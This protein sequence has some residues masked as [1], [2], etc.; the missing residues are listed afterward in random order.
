MQEYNNVSKDVYTAVGAMSGTS[1]DGLDLVI[2]RFEKARGKNDNSVSPQPFEDS[3]PQS[4]SL[5]S[6]SQVSGKFQSGGTASW[7]YNV[8]KAVTLSYSGT[9]WPARLLDAETAGGFRLMELHRDFGRFTGEAV[10]DLLKGQW[11]AFCCTGESY[12]IAR[13]YSLSPP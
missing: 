5:T 9:E 8:L 13:T 2:C 7:E 10:N 12:C 3:A 1:L 11:S 4:Q 6:T